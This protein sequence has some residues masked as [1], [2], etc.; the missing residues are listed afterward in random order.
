MKPLLTL[1]LLTLAAALPRLAAQ[2]LEADFEM[3][4]GE[5]MP[6]RIYGASAA[7]LSAELRPASGAVTS[8][9]PYERIAKVKFKD[10]KAADEALASTAETRLDG[11]QKEWDKWKPYTA[12][13]DSP[14]PRLGLALSR[15]LVG[16][17]Q[18]A[19]AKELLA[20][21]AARSWDKHI[22]ESAKGL[23]AIVD[24]MGTGSAEL[25]AKS[26]EVLA[27][28]EEPA[29]RSEANLLI[30]AAAVTELAAFLK[31][32]PRWE[33]DPLTRPDYHR[34]YN[35]A[36]DNFLSPYLTDGRNASA[37]ARGLSA[38][39]QVYAANGHPAEAKALAR[40]LKE[41]YPQTPEA[42]LA[43][44]TYLEAPAP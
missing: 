15:E 31:E 21:L 37:A 26:G 24:L 30:G 12:L 39:A 29:Q 9:V 43:A 8:V 5:K 40:D 2:T 16:H 41:L 20:L 6:G 13:P 28:L 17:G 34:L 35:L 22:A 7:G 32:N 38:A 11:L 4:N 23:S 19:P 25:L 3:R 10:T 14:A 1:V 18:P 27:K 44:K 33:L 42:V 36:L